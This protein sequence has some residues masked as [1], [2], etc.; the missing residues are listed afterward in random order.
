MAGIVGTWRPL[1]ITG[2]A[3]PPTADDMGFAEAVISFRADG[4]WLGSDGCNGLGGK[5]RL[6]STGTFSMPGP[7]SSTLIGCVNVPNLDVLLKATHVVVVGKALVFQAA[8]GAVLGVYA[9]TS[10]PKPTR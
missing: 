2:W 5:Y 6:E 4:T 10:R 1:G 3:K 8:D 7:V 9:R